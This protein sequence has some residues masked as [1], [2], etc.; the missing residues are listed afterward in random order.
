MSY[1]LILL[2]IWSLID[3]DCLTVSLH[4]SCAVISFALTSVEVDVLEFLR[5]LGFWGEFCVFDSPR[6][7]LEGVPP[8]W[9]MGNSA[10]RQR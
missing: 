7:P 9:M 1:Y 10:N 4:L 5:T 6:S 3:G 2:V 8:S